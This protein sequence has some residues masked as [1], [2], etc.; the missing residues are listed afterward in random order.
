MTALLVRDREDDLSEEVTSAL[1]ALTV[2]TGH[3]RTRAE[4]RCYPAAFHSS[5]L[6]LTDPFLLDG[7]WMDVLDL[8]IGD[9]ERANLIVLPPRGNVGLYARIT[10]QGACDFVADAFSAPEL[11]GI[12]RAALDEALHARPG[13]D[14]SLEI[15]KPGIRSSRLPACK[16]AD[17]SAQPPQEGLSLTRHIAVMFA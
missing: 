11:N 6:T 5:T 17:R 1:E 10:G 13:R 7:D 3:V 15:V 9:R 14:G 16:S 12:L 4:A 2:T 8:A